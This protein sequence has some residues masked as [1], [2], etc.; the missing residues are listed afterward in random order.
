MPDDTPLI[1][2]SDRGLQYGE[3]IP[4]T[5][6]GYVHASTSSAASGPHLWV[7]VADESDGA[8]EKAAHLT[9]ASARLLRDQLTALID[10][11]HLAEEYPDV[12]CPDCGRPADWTGTSVPGVP[13]MGCGRYPAAVDPTLDHGSQRDG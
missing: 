7:R 1:T 3:R 6:G 10:G 13:C 11:H 2:R 5:Y 12:P 8:D 4:S 9:L